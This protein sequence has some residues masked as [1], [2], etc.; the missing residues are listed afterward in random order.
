MIN[1]ISISYVDTKIIMKSLLMEK[2]DFFK[3]TSPVFRKIAFDTFDNKD[4]QILGT[5]IPG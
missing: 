3:F 4:D 5:I 2:S 1:K